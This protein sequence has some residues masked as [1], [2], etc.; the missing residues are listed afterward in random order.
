MELLLI[1]LNKGLQSKYSVPQ[2]MICAT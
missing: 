2:F 1:L